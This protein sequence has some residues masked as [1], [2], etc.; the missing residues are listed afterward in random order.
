MPGQ[1]RKQHISCVD[2]RTLVRLASCADELNQ[3]ILSAI[4]I[5]LPD[6]PPPPLRP[7]H[8]PLNRLLLCV[9]S[10][11]WAASAPTAL[12]YVRSCPC[13]RLQLL[14]PRSPLCPSL[15]LDS[16]SLR[17]VRRIDP[18]PSATSSIMPSRIV[19]V[20]APRC[21]PNDGPSSA[22]RSNLDTQHRLHV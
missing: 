17:L 16:D 19:P 15:P 20:S 22:R 4:G 13:N 2:V 10:S 12:G 3:P 7:R 14:W 1:S 21:L 5:H 11:G 9:T 18:M 8:R 6:H